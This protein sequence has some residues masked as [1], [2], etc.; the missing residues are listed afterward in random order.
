M[1]SRIMLLIPQMLGHLSVQRRLEHVLGQLVE[2]SA[3]TDQL[4][5]LLLG[6][7]QQL[8]SKLLL[9]NDIRSHRPDHLDAIG[10]ID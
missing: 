6:L 10:R 5:V 4:D 1:P 3:R 7:L 9:I 8:L 2:Q